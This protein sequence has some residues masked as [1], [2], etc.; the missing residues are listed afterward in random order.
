MMSADTDA[1]GAV[2]QVELEE[3][4]QL[5]HQV[6]DLQHTLEDLFAR[7]EAVKE[8]NMKLKSENQ[9]LRH[10]LRNLMSSSHVFH[11]TKNKRM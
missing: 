8:E 3:Q 9:V 11:Y 7:V 2:N 6:L 1:V 10:Y 4:T 5:I